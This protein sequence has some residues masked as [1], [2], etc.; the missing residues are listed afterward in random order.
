MKMTCKI[1]DKI[2]KSR[3]LLCI[4]ILLSAGMMIYYGAQKEGYHVDEL[5]SYG[6]A[7][8][9]YLPFMHFGVS[10]Y[11]VKDW[12]IE[13]GAGESLI[14]LGK[15]LIKD[16]RI[17]KECDFNWQESVIYRDYVIAQANSSDT[18]TSTWVPGEDYRNYLSVSEE[19]TFN[20]AS[21]YY[22]QRGDVHPPLYYIFLHTIC[23]I[24][25]FGFSKWQGL[26]INILFMCLTLFVLFRMVSRFLGGESVALATVLAYGFSCAI[27]T[28]TVFLRMYALLTLI[29]VCCCYVH[30]ELADQE[31]RLSKSL[32]RKLIFVVLMG[33]MT[34]Y[35]FVLYAIGIALVSCIWM[36]WKR[37]W[38]ALSAYLGA[39]V[40]SAVLGIV[41]W[42]FS[43]KHVFSGYRGRES[44]NALR[45]DNFYWVK[46][47]WISGHIFSQVFGGRQWIF[48]VTVLLAVVIF[49][50]LRGKKISIG[51][52]ALIGFPVLLYLVTVSQIV[53]YLE[54]RYIMC[55]FPFFAVYVVCGVSYLWKRLGEKFAWMPAGIAR[56]LPFVMGGLLLLCNNAFFHRPG[57]LFPGGQETIE[58]PEHTVCVYVLPDSDWN[59]SAQETN[60]LA[61][62]DQVAVCYLSDVECLSGTYEYR[63]G[64]TV[65]IT[66]QNGVDLVTAEEN[67]RK[68]LG[69]TELPEISRRTDQNNIKIFIGKEMQ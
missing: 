15:N 39:L 23:S 42:P 6:L 16:F 10:G 60:L 40:G 58:I 36:V 22:N 54:D 35:Y 5:Y 25:R 68:A 27:M 62:C 28:T 55:T 48:F 11:D 63:D 17:L 1:K 50:V 57:Y 20:Y 7:N 65:M 49:A 24:F 61:K 44:L 21:V 29:V 14:D 32:R 31:F 66:V 37:K 46:L 19:N 52:L 43:V 67:V 12:M 4:F 53:P 18:R 47:Q 33:Y 34:H 64:Q 51:K 41:I 3:I 9:E 69:I 26:A 2:N 59:E 38:R 45:S 8:S 13:Y 56:I 30:L